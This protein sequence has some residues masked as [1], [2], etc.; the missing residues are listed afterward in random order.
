VVLV[1]A[2]DDQSAMHGAVTQVPLVRLLSLPVSHDEREAD[3]LQHR[4]RHPS[5]RVTAHRV[6]EV[7][8]ERHPTN[9][10]DSQ[11]VMHFPAELDVVESVVTEQPVQLGLVLCRAQDAM[12]MVTS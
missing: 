12:L 8:A 3:V 2:A 11:E 9:L 1:E 5:P 7:M 6:V 4:A 10:H